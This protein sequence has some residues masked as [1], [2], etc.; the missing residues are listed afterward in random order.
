M[1]AA[2]GR[3]KEAVS[4]DCSTAEKT[5]GLYRFRNAA[6]RKAPLCTSPRHAVPRKPGGR[7]NRT[8]FSP[9]KPVFCTVCAEKNVGLYHARLPSGLVRD[10][11]L[12][13]PAGFL[14]AILKKRY[15]RR[16]FSTA[17]SSPTLPPDNLTKA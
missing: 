3:Q 12:V 5:R 16:D 6:P 8:T 17:A 2:W 14:G 1:R 13:R 15:G 4:E 7:T 11:P 10:A 9:R